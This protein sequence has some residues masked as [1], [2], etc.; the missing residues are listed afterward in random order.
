[1]LLV[2]GAV[3][4]RIRLDYDQV[5]GTRGTSFAAGYDSEIG[6]HAALQALAA[7]RSCIKV[8]LV[9][10]TGD[11]YEAGY[12]LPKLRSE[13]L[14]TVAVIRKDKLP[15]GV[16]IETFAGGTL[17][18][19]H[20][21]LGASADISHEQIPDD[22]LNDKTV[23]LCQTDIDPEQ[24]STLLA[25]AKKHGATTILHMTARATLAPADYAHIDYLVVDETRALDLKGKPLGKIILLHENMDA[26]LLPMDA[27]TRITAPKLPIK[28]TAGSSDAFCG[29]LAASLYDKMPLDKAVRRACAAAALAAAK[30]GAYS[31]IPFGADIE[32]ALKS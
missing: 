10:A 19:T 5:P 20:I 4:K 26:T 31:A 21:A 8:A 29:T 30:P 16:S 1:M 27:P 7:S 23:L 2:F 22:I 14:S 15:T 13:G 24:N 11:G 3:L 9:S 18:S 12:M 28:D 25:R 32:K 6:G 17:L